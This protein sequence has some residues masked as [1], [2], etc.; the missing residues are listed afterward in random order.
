MAAGE[1][2]LGKVAR[3][4]ARQHALVDGLATK[5]IDI[6][7]LRQIG[8]MNASLDLLR[9]SIAPDLSTLNASLL[10]GAEATRTMTAALSAL[11][12]SKE[13][14]ESLALSPRWSSS[15]VAIGKTSVAAQLN[16]QLATIIQSNLLAEEAIARIAARSF[17]VSER[18]ADIFHRMGTAQRNLWLGPWSTFETLS[19]TPR[20]AVETAG[21]DY[22]LAAHQ[23]DVSPTDA[24]VRPQ[25]ESLLA[26]LSARATNVPTLIASLGAELLVPYRGA[27][28]AIRSNNP[29]RIRHAAG[30]LRELF[31]QVLHR[32]APDSDVV[33]WISDTSLLDD[34]GRP[35]RR[36]RLLY[37]SRTINHGEF[38][39]LIEADLAGALEFLSVLQKGTHK[40]E[41]T[42]FL[43]DSQLRALQVR[44]DS[45]LYNLI[46]IGT[47][48][49]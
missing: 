5:L 25:D 43:T 31:T 33:K 47:D 22:Y 27:A 23:L 1:P 29:D 35:T 42:P 17:L 38:V 20:V 36:A 49:S 28:E 26:E 9:R 7:M 45:L 48:R 14:F 46:Q 13:L 18:F 37:V 10:M 11:G 44:M 16:R 34:K 3:A 32:L 4:Y 21:T 39:E 24:E 6:P 12:P 19:A 8:D 41:A 30:S 15:L 2:D 40:V